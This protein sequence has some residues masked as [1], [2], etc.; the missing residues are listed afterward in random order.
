MNHFAKTDPKIKQPP[1]IF[2]K[3]SIEQIE[4]AEK[5]IQEQAAKQEKIEK[6][7]RQRIEKS[8]EAEAPPSA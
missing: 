5:E 2:E 6:E 1:F 3:A 4:Q 8:K 7:I